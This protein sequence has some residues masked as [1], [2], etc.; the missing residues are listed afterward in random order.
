[1]SVISVACILKG[2]E[3]C[4]TCNLNCVYKLRTE[5]N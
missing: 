1:M 3:A 4:K 2:T 5:N